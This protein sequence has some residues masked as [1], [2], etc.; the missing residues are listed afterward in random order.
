MIWQQAYTLTRSMKTCRSRYPSYL[1]KTTIGWLALIMLN[2]LAHQIYEIIVVIKFKRCFYSVFT[3]WEWDRN[4]SRALL[5]KRL[6][7]E[8]LPFHNNAGRMLLTA[9]RIISSFSRG[10]LWIPEPSVGLGRIISHNR[11]SKHMFLHIWS[12]SYWPMV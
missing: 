3:V 6:S 9:Y 5:N 1:R 7:R 12:D 10:R 4:E 11:M 8:I 2:N